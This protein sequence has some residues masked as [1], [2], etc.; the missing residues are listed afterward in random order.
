MSAVDGIQYP[1]LAILNI[2]KSEHL[3]LY[4]KAIFG[5]PER[6]RYDIIRYNWTD[7]YH[8]LKEAAFTFGFKSAVLIVTSRYV[9]NANTEFKDNTMS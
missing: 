6:D 7:F 4:N 8:E 9:H 1:Y 3:K 5:L 2:S